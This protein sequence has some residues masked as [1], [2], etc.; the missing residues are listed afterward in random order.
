VH[1]QSKFTKS[2]NKSQKEFLLQISICVSKNPEFYADFDSVE[3]V[4]KN[5]PEKVISKNMTE[6]CTFLFPHVRQT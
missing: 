3:K 2:A 6:I 5:V 1:L 4:W